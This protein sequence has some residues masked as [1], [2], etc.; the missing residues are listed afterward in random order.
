[1]AILGIVLILYGLGVL[2]VIGYSHWFDAAG[3][4]AGIGCIGL[5]LW[6]SRICALR[7]PVPRILGGLLAVVVISFFLLEGAILGAALQAPLPGAAYVII[8]GAKVN[9]TV[10]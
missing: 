10:P 1:M 9:G 5:A 4:L 8:P 7:K 3:I 6:G 2:A